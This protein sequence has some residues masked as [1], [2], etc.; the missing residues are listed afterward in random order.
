MALTTAESTNKAYRVQV[1]S[2]IFVRTAATI[3]IASCALAATA[4]PAS[5]AT[6][7]SVNQQSSSGS[8]VSIRIVGGYQADRAKTGFFL[9]FSPDLSEGPTLCGATKLNKYWAVTAGHC[10]RT[11]SKT[12]RTGEGRSYVLVNPKTRDAGKKYYLSK[13]VVNPGY[14]PNSVKQFNDLALIRTIKPMPGPS[15]PINGNENLPA[16]GTAAQV[17]GFGFRHED[18]PS[19]VSR[20]LREADIQVL[21]GPGAG[22]Q[23]GDYG[24]S[25]DGRYQL[26]AGEIQGQTDACS[27]DSGGPL[28]ARLGKKSRLIGIVSSGLGCALPD[29]PG[30][31]TKVSKYSKWITKFT[32]SKIYIDSCELC[33]LKKN[34]SLK[35]R[36]RD[37]YPTS[38]HYKITGGG[39]AVSV[40]QRSGT[41]WGDRSASVSV[42]L[43]TSAS[44]CIALKVHASES[45]TKKIMIAANG[46]DC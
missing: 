39:S 29:Y 20:Y 1:T 36:L 44:K 42:K 26:C 23:C 31:Y 9:R 13:V 3:A 32:G 4:F 6:S 45:H 16:L 22:T 7:A 38:G 40:S 28:V 14:R 41:I 27:G 37:M 2:R 8:K 12:A 25:F 34:K 43:K 11:P 5:A 15:L 19:S 18:D 35:I 17:Y 33:N 21:A 24:A 10:V 46:R 30:I